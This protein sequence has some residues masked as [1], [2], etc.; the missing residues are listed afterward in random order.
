MN[1]LTIKKINNAHKIIK[2]FITVTPLITNEYI[3]RIT[4]AIDNKKRPSKKGIIEK[5]AI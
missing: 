4:K 3:N 2:N 5:D 1:K